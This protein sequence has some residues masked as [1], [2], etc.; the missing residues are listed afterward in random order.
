MTA[1]LRCVVVAKKWNVSSSWV[2]AAILASFASSCKKETDFFPEVKPIEIDGLSSEY[3]ENPVT[4][5]SA[6]SPYQNLVWADEFN[7]PS[8]S[9]SDAG[10]YSRPLTCAKRLDWDM[11]GPCEG[12]DF[13]QLADLDK[14]T[15]AVASGFSFWEQSNQFFLS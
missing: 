2:L 6:A 12:N 11:E 10:C 15:W 13:S 4:P 14:C 1:S 7:G 5:P 9:Y 3:C 8:G